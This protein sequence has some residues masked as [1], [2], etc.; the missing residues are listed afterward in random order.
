[1][2]KFWRIVMDKLRFASIIVTYRCNAKCA[3]CHIWKYPSRPEEEFKPEL[4]EKLPF[5]DT[6]NITGGEPFLRKDIYD[7]I[8]ILKK[9]T[10]R[11]VISTNGFWTEKI[12]EIMKKYKDLGIRISI[13]GLPVTNAKLRGIKDGFDRAL[14][15][16]MELKAMGCKDIGLAMTVSGDN[17]K[18]LVTLFRLAHN[19]NMEFATAAV[20]NSYYFHKFDNEIPNKKE[21]IDEFLKLINE[22]FCSNRIKDW[23]RAYFNYGIIN[24]ILGRPRLLPCEMGFDAFFLDP[25]GNVRPCN[26]MDEIMGNLHKKSFEE[27]W[28]SEQAEKVRQKVKNCDQRCWMIGSVAHQMKKYIW[29]PTWWIIKHKFFKRPICILGS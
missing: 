26:V 6:I 21:V 18:D 28:N 3:M 14:K 25:Y 9:K 2:T 17:V 29:K 11:I 10:K 19:L 24:Y 20:H 4:L 8:D 12:I 1:M 27:I 22:L 16:L 13:E 23:Y 7:I 5:I 15:T